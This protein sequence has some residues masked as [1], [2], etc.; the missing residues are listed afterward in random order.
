MKLHFLIFSLCNVAEARFR[1]P[2]FKIPSFKPSVPKI[3]S[4]KPPRIPKPSFPRPSFPKPSTNWLGNGLNAANLAANV[5]TLAMMG[6]GMSEADRLQNEALKKQAEMQQ[7]QYEYEK[8][9]IE[10]AAIA[11]EQ[12]APQ[13]CVDCFNEIEQMMRA[14]EEEAKVYCTEMFSKVPGWYDG[15]T[16]TDKS[17]KFFFDAKSIEIFARF[18]G[19]DNKCL[20]A[21]SEYLNQLETNPKCQMADYPSLRCIYD[22]YHHQF[23]EMKN[24]CP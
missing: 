17:K 6:I 3:P 18:G 22:K 23:E 15:E 24:S 1:L 13:V 2:G 11:D 21:K 14:F 5:G 19:K 20:K 8:S 9:L 10:M 16:C 12:G 4:F 7:Q